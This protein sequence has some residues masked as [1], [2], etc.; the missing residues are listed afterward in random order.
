MFELHYIT[1]LSCNISQQDLDH[2]I[3]MPTP[4]PKYSS[5]TLKYS[6]TEP[7][8]LQVQTRSKT[9]V[10]ENAAA[11]YLKAEVV[12]TE[13]F[14]GQQ[15]ST[16]GNVL[17]GD[18]V[19]HIG[20]RRFKGDIDEFVTK[21]G[22]Q[23][24]ARPDGMY[25]VTFA[26]I[27]PPAASPSVSKEKKKKPAPEPKKKSTRS[28]RSSSRGRTTKAPAT[29]TASATKAKPKVKK[30]TP[31]RRTPSK[32]GKYSSRQT[33]NKNNSTQ[34][35]SVEEENQPIHF[36]RHGTRVPD[37]GNQDKT[38]LHNDIPFF[39]ALTTYFGYV[40]LTIF[41]RL[42]DF[43]GRCT[44]GG[45][46]FSPKNAGPKD[47]AP[48]VDSWDNFYAR[49][50]KH[51]IND[52]FQRPVTGPPAA[53]GM[54]LL[55][56][57]TPDQNKTFQ[58]TGETKRVINLGSY[59]YL[60]FADDWKE[61]CRDSVVSTFDDFGT[62]MCSSP[63]DA[64]T[65][66][67]HAELEALVCEFLNKEACCVF[68]MG[69]GTN[70]STIPALVGKGGLIVSDRYVVIIVWLRCTVLLLLCFVRRER[71]QKDM[72]VQ[73]SF[74]CHSVSHYCYRF[75]QISLILFPL[76]PI[77]SLLQSESF[78]HCQWRTCIGCI[79]SCL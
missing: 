43:F 59:N 14:E 24:Q 23:R 56:R 70:A 50:M 32:G 3:T 66:V 42:R 22:E 4:K 76:S 77:Y 7:L 5:Y 79:R 60:G 73:N 13:V 27:L 61:T 33:K 45:R 44:G 37:Q 29:L 51:R 2:T 41:G 78:L 20:K 1:V 30:Q 57:D 11:D 62:S 10:A 39:V 34:Q 16:I 17:I 47:K 75:P 68:N 63:M 58:L 64:G 28:T 72:R 52:I 49:R 25:T 35:K 26:R 15:S 21:V 19:T 31:R 40:V 38:R 9:I 48:I 54:N 12:V 69:Y 67:V 8:G 65:T 46:Y 36:S 53:S 6:G 71:I 74:L 18:V 55:V